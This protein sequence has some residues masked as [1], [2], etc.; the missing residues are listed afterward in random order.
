MIFPILSLLLAACRCPKCW[1]GQHPAHKGSKEHLKA[2]L[3]SGIL[4]Q[5][6]HLSLRPVEES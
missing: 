5:N 2:G 4:A 1:Q 3:P 6:N